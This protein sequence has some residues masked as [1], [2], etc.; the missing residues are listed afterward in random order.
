MRI[1]GPKGTFF[2]KD[3]IKPLILIATGTGIAPIKAIVEVLIAK[4][5]KRDVHIYCRA[6]SH[7]VNK[8]DLIASNP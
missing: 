5:D 1:E 8:Y 7:F 4:E 2:V 3:N 6:G